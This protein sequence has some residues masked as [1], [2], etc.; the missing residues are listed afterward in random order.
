LVLSLSRL[1]ASEPS[2]PERLASMILRHQP[3]RA[4]RPMT[5]S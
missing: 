1:L 5:P 3:H 2:F 4:L